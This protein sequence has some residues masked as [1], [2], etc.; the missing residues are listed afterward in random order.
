MMTQKYS[1][2]AKFAIVAI[3][4]IGCFMLFGTG[5]IDASTTFDKFTSVT[6]ALIIAM[7]LNGAGSAVANSLAGRVGV[8]IGAMVLCGGGLSGCHIQPYVKSPAE[9]VT[10]SI[11]IATCV[12]G[13][14][15]SPV[16]TVAHDCTGDILT[17]TYDAIADLEAIIEGSKALQPTALPGPSL[18]ASL[19]QIAFPYSNEPE[20]MTRLQTLRNTQPLRSQH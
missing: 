9:Q 10:D 19:P 16:L 17:A 8:F 11:R 3:F 1:I 7:G 20:I 2:Y 14:W 5:R 15:G 4:M 18:V 13:D 12:A 6:M